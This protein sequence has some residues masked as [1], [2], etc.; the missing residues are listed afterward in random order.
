MAFSH[1][2]R[3][4]KINGMTIKNRMG[5]SAMVSSYN[6]ENGD[7]TERYKAYHEAKAKG[8]FGLIITENYPIMPLA[9]GFRNL[10]GMWDDKHIEQNRDL[11]A[12]VHVAGGKIVCQIYHAGYKSVCARTKGIT[13]GSASAMK[14]TQ[15]ALSYTLS[16]EEIQEI[17]KKFAEAAVKQGTGL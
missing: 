1:L 3:P 16:R 5:V 8:G 12:R 7:I 10:P 6:Q 15:G 9:G 13:P 17:V 4:L 2:L 11:T 14:G